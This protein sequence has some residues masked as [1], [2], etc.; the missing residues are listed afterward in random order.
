M[1]KVSVIRE[2]AIGSALGLVGGAAWKMFH[3][4]EKRKVAQFYHDLAKK[5][6]K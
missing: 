5:E 4:S 1:S 3:F 2:I 6:G